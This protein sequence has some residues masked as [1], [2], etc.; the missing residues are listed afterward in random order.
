MASKENNFLPNDW[1]FFGT[2]GDGESNERDLSFVAMD[3]ILVL[4]PTPAVTEQILQ[5]NVR[6]NEPVLKLMQ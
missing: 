4:E 6:I 2:N 3:C 1:M 5:C